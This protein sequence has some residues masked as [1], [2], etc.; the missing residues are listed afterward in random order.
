[1]R[2]RL[3]ATVAAAAAALALSTTAADAYVYW[4]NFG[5]TLA[6]GGTTIGRADLDAGGVTN[7]FIAG[8]SSPVGLA[9]DGRYIY[10]TNAG[11]NSIGRANLDGTGAN[12]EFVPNATSGTPAPEPQSVAVDGGHVYW[13]DNIRY[14]G[15]AN[16][17]GTDPQPHFIDFGLNSGPTGIGVDATTLYA[18]AHGGQI[19]SVSKTGGA[20]ALFYQPLNTTFT[21]GLAVAGGYVYWGGATAG[22]GEIGRIQV[23]GSNPQDSFITQLGLPTALASDGNELYWADHGMDTVGRA[24]LTTGGAENIDR[25]LVS[26]PA[27]PWGVAMDGLIDPTQTTVACTPVVAVGQPDPCTITVADSASSEPATGTVSLNSG[28]SAFFAASSCTLGGSGPGSRSCT[29]GAI[30]PTAAT[31]PITASYAGD[32]THQASTA[33][34]AFCAGTA[35]ECGTSPAP[36]PPPPHCVVPR[37]KG[38]TLTRA[39]ALLK[40]AHCALGKVTRPRH[41]THHKLLVSKQSPAAGRKLSSGARV[42]VTLTAARRH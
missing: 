2:S 20:P 5:P 17:D 8:A 6:G 42:A 10:W 39:K 13:S 41:R 26:V 40:A 9:V 35:T 24:T 21:F 37:L 15:R 22:D 19:W 34:T 1:M 33:T 3:L 7:A 4:T 16:L 23:N 28:G 32:S 18:V 38:K 14:I 11:T 27:G 12:P 31:V 29:I 36:P 30:S 25:S